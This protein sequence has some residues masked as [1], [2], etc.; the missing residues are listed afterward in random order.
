MISVVVAYHTRP[1]HFKNTLDS[2][3]HFYSDLDFEVVVIEDTPRDHGKECR[4]V[5]EHSGLKF[6]HEVVDR[7]SKEYRNPGVLY[8]RGV[9]IAD[10]NY[11]HLTNP[12]N[13]H[14]GPILTHC[15]DYIKLDNYIVYGCRTLG[16]VPMSFEH[17][18]GNID[19][20]TNWNEAWGWY[21]HS[22]IYNRLLHFASIISKELYQQIGGFDPR[23]DNGT[24]YEDNDFIKRIKS[25]NIPVLTFDEPFAAHQAHDRG[26]WMNFKGSDI[27]RIIYEEIWKEQTI[28][29]WR[30]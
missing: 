22:T 17:T 16:I 2:Y 1:H 14:C 7:S 13:L 15:L 3:K 4:Y 24:G 12:E 9:E 28:E 26:H 8:N 21:Q 23:F 29:H 10:G 30:S 5:L 20:M 6:K 25:N 18:I 19:N 11:I 27:N